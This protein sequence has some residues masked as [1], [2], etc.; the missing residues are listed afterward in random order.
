VRVGTW[1]VEW[2]KPDSSKAKRSEPILAAPDC[3]VLCVTEGDAGILPRA[4]T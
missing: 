4:A 2:A 3:N 1:N